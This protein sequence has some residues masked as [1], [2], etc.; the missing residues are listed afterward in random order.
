VG[1]QKGAIIQKQNEL[2]R[3]AAAAFLFYFIFFSGCGPLWRIFFFIISRKGTKKKAN[4][5]FSVYKK[6][7]G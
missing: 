2:L 6:E 5:I 7:S 4:S 3:G 1:Y